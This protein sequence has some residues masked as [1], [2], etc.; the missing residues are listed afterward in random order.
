M[1]VAVGAASRVVVQ[2]V[3]GVV[4]VLKDALQLQGARGLDLERPTSGDTPLHQVPELPLNICMVSE[5]FLQILATG[6]GALALVWATVV[7]LG[8]FSTSLEK[9]DFWV[10]TAIVFIQTARV[11][12]INVSPEAEFFN[13]VP[14]AFL[15]LGA[16]QYTKWGRGRPLTG[17]ATGQNFVYYLMLALGSAR[18]FITIVAFL[19]I[20]VLAV[21]MIAGLGCISLSIYRLIAILSRHHDNSNVFRALILFYALVLLQGGLFILWL[22]LR[23]YRSYLANHVSFK[24]GLEDKRELIDKYM[25]K[26][27]SMAIK[28]GVSSTINRNLASFAAE[29]M[30]SEY[31][32]D[33]IDAVLVMHRLTS[34]EDHRTR[35]LSQIQSSPLCVSR[36]LDMVTSK[37]RTDQRTK[38]C[39]AQIVAHLASNLPLADISGATESISS[40]IDP[41]FT[42]ISTPATNVNIDHQTAIDITIDQQGAIQSA[43]AANGGESNGSCIFVKQLMERVARQRAE[44][45]RN[46]QQRTLQSSRTTSGAESKPLIIHGLLI[47][48]KLAVNPDNCK[49]IYDYKGLFSKIISPVKNKVYEILRDDGITME[50]TEKA[51]EVVSMLVSGTDETNE[52]IRQDICSNGIV[53]H[54]I[55]SILEKDHMYDKLK[56]P[57][58]KILTELS[59]DTSTRA[60]L[61]LDGVADFINDLMDIFFD[62]ANESEGLKKTAGEALAVLATDNANCMTIMNFSTETNT[63]VQLLTDMI[64]VVN[65]RLYQTPIAQLLMQLCANSNPAER[66]EHLASVKTNL[67]EV[68]K[69][70]CNVEQAENA[71]QVGS[72]QHNLGQQ[73]AAYT[74]QAGSPQHNLV[75]QQAAN[76]NANQVGSPQHN[77]GQQQAANNANQVG[78]P[79]HNSGQQQAANANQ[80]GSPQHNPGQQQVANANQVGSPQHNLEQQQAANAN[81]TGSPQHNRGRPPFSRALYRLNSFLGAQHSHAANRNNPSDN[82]PAVAQLEGAKR[83]SLAAFLGLTLQ[84]CDKLE[85]SPDDFDNALALI[86]LS[87]DD[88]VDKLNHIIEQCKGHSFDSLEGKGPSLEYLMIIKTVT[89]LCTWMM[90][91]KP[92]CIRVFQNKNTSTKLQGALEDMRDLELGMLLTGSAGD[93]ANYQTL[94]TIV[95]VARQMMDA[96]VQV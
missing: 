60:T 42:K 6:L 26:T 76:A 67:H 62:A 80:A 35:T 59:L 65:H 91:H 51:L 45:I 2:L 3:R 43:S 8:G 96:N 19:A 12:G 28:N 13:Q 23:L 73:Q 75:Q 70:I 20:L 61:G 22:F 74:N 41:Y 24:Y 95:G 10:I 36:L 69:V 17:R 66:E 56:V 16:E 52:K 85:I 53:A 93:M 46:R 34:Q 4:V 29:M 9:A 58:T 25:D 63:S 47:L 81:Q 14:P 79:Q 57:A 84:I 38:L 11:V 27:L 54:N 68:L 92:D 7:L 1:E 94:S 83:K 49:H 5:M 32:Q 89:K 87:M 86:P 77:P 90:Q 88:F 44:I 39:I 55:C 72:P 21:P 78:S 15:E 82:L 50:I 48:A 64:P 30:K 31:S 37:S 18:D 33:R 40:M 71:N